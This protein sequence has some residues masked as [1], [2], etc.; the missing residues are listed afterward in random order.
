MHNAMVPAI[1]ASSA[2]VMPPDTLPPVICIFTASVSVLTDTSAFST[3][4][5]LFTV[6]PVIVSCNGLRIVAPVIPYTVYADR[7]PE[8]AGSSKSATPS[9]SSS[10]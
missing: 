2:I 6:P 7:S 1:S 4:V 10:I 5:I 3:T 8:Y 9:K